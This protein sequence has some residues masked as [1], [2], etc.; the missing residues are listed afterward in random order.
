MKKNTE[1]P[2]VGYVFQESLAR[3]Q[4]AFAR[5][6]EFIFM[7]A[8][9]QAKWVLVSLL[10]DLFKLCL[11]VQ[12]GTAVN[13]K[14]YPLLPCW[15]SGQEERQDWKEDPW[16]P[17]ESVLGCAQACGKQAS[18]SHLESVF[19][20]CGKRGEPYQSKGKPGVTPCTP[21]GILVNSL[22]KDHHFGVGWPD[23]SSIRFNF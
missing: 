22:R 17:R 10:E 5:K 15:Q 16:Q 20:V 23:L 14:C 2:H 8:E 1:C 19:S 12:R 6:W 9:A 4:R 18:H 7:Q 11:F 3:L 21:H 13:T